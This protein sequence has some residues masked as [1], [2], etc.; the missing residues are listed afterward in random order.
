MYIYIY[1][2]R[3]RDGGGVWDCKNWSLRKDWKRVR[4]EEDKEFRKYV[5]HH[6]VMSFSHAMQFVFIWWSNYESLWLLNYPVG[7]ILNQFRQFIVMT[8][9]IKWKLKWHPKCLQI[10]QYIIQR[11]SFLNLLVFINIRQTSLILIHTHL[12]CQ[13]SLWLSTIFL[14]EFSSII[15]ILQ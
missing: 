1:I 2:E 4:K 5:Y 15:D 14:S 10:I 8:I 7:F 11:Q 6:N 12:N 13:H 3:E 9:S